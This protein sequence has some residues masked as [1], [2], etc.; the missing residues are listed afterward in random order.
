MSHWIDTL[1]LN[2][3]LKVR[4]DMAIRAGAMPA[5]QA[6]RYTSGL[7]VTGSAIGD[8]AAVA[9]VGTVPNLL[10]RGIGPRTG[11]SG[12]FDL[13]QTV[14]KGGKRAQ[15]IQVAPGVWRT[16]SQ[17]KPW[18]HPG[19]PRRNFAREAQQDIKR[20]VRVLGQS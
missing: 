19:F 10:E 5:N 9:L 20:I 17:A 6:R 3:A 16:L 18:T 2:V 11:D 7:M 12:P 1:A 14:L 15:S 13:R 8:E 4:D